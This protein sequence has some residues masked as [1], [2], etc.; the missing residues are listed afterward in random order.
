[1][2][3][4]KKMEKLTKPPLGLIPKEFYYEHVNRKRFQE[5]CEAITRYYNAGL[6]INIEWVEEYNELIKNK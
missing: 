1:M 6:Q 2:E 3:Q 5:V 4:A